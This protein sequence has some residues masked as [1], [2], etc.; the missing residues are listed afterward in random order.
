[1][2]FQDHLQ[3]GEHGQTGFLQQ[4]LGNKTFLS[5]YGGAIESSIETSE[6]TP[7]SEALLR[8]KI[9]QAAIA[10][11]GGQQQVRSPYATLPV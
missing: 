2:K 10:T 1:M 4:T 5:D 3:L 8:T 7:I 11:V 9:S 6:L